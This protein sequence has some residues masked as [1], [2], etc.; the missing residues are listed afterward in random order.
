MKEA[1]Q[2]IVDF[3]CGPG[4][5]QKV[6]E[7]VMTENLFPNTWTNVDI[8]KKALDYCKTWNKET[9]I[10][11]DFVLSNKIP[12]P[13]SENDLLIATYSLCELYE[14]DKSLTEIL[15][16]YKKIL[17]LEPGQK[18]ESKKLIHLR[19]DLI[20]N[21]SFFA[22]SPCTHQELCPM[23]NEKKYWCHDHVEKPEFLNSLDLP[24]S[25]DKLNFSYLYISK[26]PKKNCKTFGRVVGD[27][28]LEK[29]KTKVATCFDGTITYLSWLKKTKLSIQ[30]NRG[31]LIRWVDEFKRKGHE[32]RIFKPLQKVGEE[33]LNDSSGG[34]VSDT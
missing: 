26:E 10:K 1:P 14:K 4:T 15:K 25:Q 19:N 27:L 9:K 30:I 6:F 34:P 33:F 23:T 18:E 24:F 20:Q 8:S 29:G 2:N 16:L 11:T 21:H 3:G 28:R 12:K 7:H 32:I 17:I 5:V 22:H 13:Q 31:D